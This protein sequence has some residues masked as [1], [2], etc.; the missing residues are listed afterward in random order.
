[1]LNQQGPDLKSHWGL[2]P[3]IT[4]LNHGSFGAC[5]IEVLRELQRLQV[6][7]EREPA[8]FLSREASVRLGAARESLGEFV[9]ADP[10]DLVYVPNVTVAINSVL[11][12]LPLC[13]GDEL[14]VSSHEYNASRNVLEYVAE[15]NRCRV[16]V[17]E[18]PFPIA[19]PHVVLERM[20]DAITPRTRL[21]LVDHVTSATGLLMPLSEL[22]ELF[23]EHDVEV[24][25]DGAHAPGMIPVDLRALAP[26][27]YTGNCHKWLCSP[28]GAGF[29]YVRPDLQGQVRPAV[30]SHGANANL[31]GNARFRAEFEWTGTRDITPWLCVPKAISYLA[32]LLPGGWSE[33]MNRNHELVVEGRK[34]IAAALDVA[35]PCPEQMLGSLAT[36]HL[37]DMPDFDAPAAT[38]AL[39]LNPLQEA[40]FRQ[41]KI[42]V[43]VLSCPAS[44]KPM[45][46][47]SAQLYNELSDYERL[48]G[49]LQSLL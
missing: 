38:S 21:A 33:V 9:A 39:S 49:A 1:M 7:L 22:I 40:L 11:R 44:G 48:A 20:R 37:P 14:I 18:L 28:K 30:I 26:D 23:H 4:Y 19:G 27:Y 31:E 34:L 5:P 41:Y 43:P 13:Q 47:I 29:L 2:D 16:V 35:V 25:V 24:L 3:D 42:E 8:T 10:D 45:L 46:R 17:V 15:Q 12:S 32:S 6:E 36:L